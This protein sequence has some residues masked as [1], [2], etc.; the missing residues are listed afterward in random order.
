ME[1]TCQFIRGVAGVIA[2]LVAMLLGSGC[3]K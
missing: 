1:A 3:I 2:I